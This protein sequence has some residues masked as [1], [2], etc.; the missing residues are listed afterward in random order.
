MEKKELTVE[1]LKAIASGKKYYPG[2][3]LYLVTEQIL[4]EA[5]M[6]LADAH[7]YGIKVVGRV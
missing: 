5:N 2:R 1:E 3:V 6:S 4:E 7:H